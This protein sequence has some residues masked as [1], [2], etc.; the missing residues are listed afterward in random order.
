[1]N[2]SNLEP[3]LGQIV[4]V[5]GIHRWEVYRRLQELEIACWCSS[6]QPLQV[7]IEDAVEATQLGSVLR[8]LTA[9]KH[10]LVGLLENCWLAN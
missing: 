10:E 6:G 4:E 5:S 2:K 3:K 8:Q 9:P 7:Q 1:M